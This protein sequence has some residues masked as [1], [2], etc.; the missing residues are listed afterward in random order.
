MILVFIAL[1]TFIAFK[2]PAYESDDNEPSHVQNI[3]M[4]VSGH[5]YGIPSNCSYAP[6]PF[7]VVTRCAGAEPQ[8]APLYYLILA[9]WQRAVGLPA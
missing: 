5:W 6:H 4:L 8:Q 7:S 3:E 9:G 2:T 1:G